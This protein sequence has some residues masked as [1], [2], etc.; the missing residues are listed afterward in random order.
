MLADLAIITL[1]LTRHREELVGQKDL[2][3]IFDS[4]NELT[5]VAHDLSRLLSITWDQF[6]VTRFMKDILQ[7]REEATERIW[8]N[9]N[10]MWP[11]YIKRRGNYEQ[12]LRT[13][14]QHRQLCRQTRHRD[15]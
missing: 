10:G 11:T 12:K 13:K 1:C 4:D 5:Y 3:D 9:P 2:Q 6:D 8:K 7:L 15:T 14:M